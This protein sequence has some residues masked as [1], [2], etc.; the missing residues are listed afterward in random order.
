YIDDAHGI[1]LFGDKGQG[2]ARSQMDELGSR[3]I[4]AASLGKG[5]GASGGML[6][7]GTVHQENLFRRFA[8]AHAFS[9]SINNASI[10]AAL[11]SARLHR[12]DELARLR[13]VLQ[14]RIA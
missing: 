12:T 11:A 6:M 7:L 5:F 3:T 8:V 1:S 2:F 13:A 9:A 14:K 10:G 4:V